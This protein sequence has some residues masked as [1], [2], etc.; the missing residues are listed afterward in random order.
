MSDDEIKRLKEELEKLKKELEELKRGINV[1]KTPSEV[2]FI[3]QNIIEM[4]S[5]LPKKIQKEVIKAFSMSRIQDEKGKV[6]IF[7]FKDGGKRTSSEDEKLGIEK[8]IDAILKE[9]LPGEDL[10]ETEFKLTNRLKKLIKKIDPT[11]VSDAI[12]V[13]ANPDRI[14]ILQF[15]YGADRYFSELE[16][17]LR[18]GPS[19]LRHHL[20]KLLNGGLITQERSRGKYS[21]TKRGIAALILI[22]YL[23]DKILK[24]MK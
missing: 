4:I 11:E 13:L 16:E 24:N 7:P 21:I 18:L 12:V 15:L 17:Y 6:V 3:P 19:S 22:A 9:T 23:Y 5:E 2:Q 10:I 8:E 20:S 14:K 1:E